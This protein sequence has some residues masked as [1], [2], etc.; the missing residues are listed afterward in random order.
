MSVK[1]ATSSVALPSP[2]TSSAASATPV[3]GKTPG[4]ERQLV[5]LGQ[6][7]D[8]GDRKPPEHEGERK[9][10]AEAPTP[11]QR[12]R[13]H[14]SNDSTDS[15]RGRQPADAAAAQVDQVERDRDE[16]NPEHAAHEDLGDEAADEDGHVEV[17]A[18]LHQAAHQR[19]AGPVA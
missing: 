11:G 2:M 3:C 4:A 16:E 1:P 5:G 7:T 13:V 18:Q 19:I 9:W 14:G 15:H 12:H 8:H 10:L 6:E 17:L